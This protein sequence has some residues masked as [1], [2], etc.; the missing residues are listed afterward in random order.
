MMA[1]YRDF[2]SNRI[3]RSLLGP[4]SDIFAGQNEEEV[5]SD[6]PLQRY[7][8]GILF[9]EKSIASPD[10]DDGRLELSEKEDDDEDDFSGNEDDAISGL[11][12]Q[13][14][15]KEEDSYIAANQYFPTN[16]GL[17]VCLKPDANKVNAIVS[18]AIY[19]LSKPEDVKI[20]ISENNKILLFSY[21]PNDTKGRLQYEDGK[22]F[23]IKQPVGKTKGDRS[24]DYAI[25]KQLRRT[26]ELKNSIIVEKFEQ[27]LTPENRLWK[28]H[29][30]TETILIDLATEY[31]RQTVTVREEGNRKLELL[32]KVFVDESSGNKYIKLLLYNASEKHTQNRFTNSDK[33]LNTNCFYQV[34]ITLSHSAILPYKQPSFV[35][36]QFD[37]E[38][39]LINY[40]YRSIREYGIGHGCAI[41]SEQVGANIN[42]YT[43]FLPEVNLPMVSNQLKDNPFFENIPDEQKQV[44]S[45]LLILK[46]LSIWSGITKD[47]ILQDLKTFVDFYSK[48]IEKQKKDANIELDYKE[49]SDMLIEKQ[50]LAL[51][52]LQRS[53]EL[54]KGNE[55]AFEC[56]QYT[57]TAM[58]IQLITSTDEQFAKKQKEL[59][60]LSGGS[61]V[62]DSLDFFKEYKDKGDK[63]FAYRPFQLVFLLLNLNSIINPKDNLDRNLVDLLWFPTGGGKTEAYLAVTAFTIL[64]RRI[65]HPENYQGVSV[66][67][68]YTLRLLTAQQFERASRLICA[69]EFLRCKF[70]KEE[71]D[72]KKK[73]RVYKFGED[74]ITIGMW[75]GSGTTP[76]SFK[77]AVDV[78][79]EIEDEVNRLNKTNTDN[80]D[81]AGEKNNFQ[82]EACAW[83]G[84]KVISKHPKTNKY[85]LAFDNQGKAKC[86]N[87]TCHFSDLNGNGLPI[88]VVDD[89]L[90]Q[91]PPTLLFATVDKF[92]ML[93]HKAEGHKFFNSKDDNL[94]PPDLIIQDELHL[95]NGPLG[96]VVGLFERVV[97]SL[98]T[99]NDIKPKIIAS[100]ATTRNT[101]LQTRNLYNREVAVFPPS[102]IH[103][104]DSFFAFTLKESHRKYIGFMPTGKTG[105]DT[106]LEFLAHLLFARAELL[107]K[108]RQQ[109]G[110][111][112][113]NLWKSLD[114]YF[115]L[116]S[117]YNSLKDVGK[118]YNKVNAEV[119]DKLRLLLQR[120]SKNNYLYDFMNRG[121][122]SRTREL[123][124][125]IPSN[126]I[127]PV[128]NELEA[129][130]K[131]KKNPENGTFKIERG[132]DLVLASNMI[133]VGID[134][135]RLN[136][137]LI[138]GQPRNVSE[139][140]QASS[141]VA[142]RNEGIVFNLLDANRA[143]EKS[144]FENYQ[145]FHH[146][147]YK[148]VEP[149]SLTPNTE[150][151]FD[152]MLNAVLVC[153]VRHKQGLDA[154]Q[155]T[156]NTIEFE[157]I[158]NQTIKEQS[159]QIHLKNELKK[160]ADDWI[161]K[162]Q[163]AE[164]IGKTLQYKS[165]EQTLIS[166]SEPWNLMF[167][168]REIDK[169][170]LILIQK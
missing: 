60:K 36:N 102:G 157:K 44:F 112:D 111:D 22:L 128:L 31:P 96:S 164:S 109:F 10:E 161:G 138:N 32:S 141:R 155:F 16:C 13:T 110:S 42:V 15:T 129:E 105:M 7:Y 14:T 113:D 11:M 121:L 100:T 144:Y 92:A 150:I 170:G 119:Y 124:S 126:R 40:Q 20:D 89:Y 73:K 56:F 67:M 154:H 120:F 169:Q 149:L 134:V 99:K 3:S 49:Y 62:Y 68:R 54:L 165:K 27:L 139:Y 116:V 86:L 118:T 78:H 38:A 61:E 26:E 160:L 95:L 55:E 146:A 131:V 64:W 123:T 156:G 142:R 24:G 98:C 8:T 71:D 33:K 34:R 137:M 70:I 159:L 58:Y 4:G 19:K 72:G 1:Q 104:S 163:T 162:V 108:L 21:L 132:I 84:C 35:I 88:F 51:N 50:S 106:Q 148:F 114:P 94:L 45:Q 75:V 43:T 9:P 133:S 158:I 101:E 57:N 37:P 140:I 130:L 12:K 117:Y 153:Y 151:T 93:P 76:N 97:E 87:D 69:L 25:P 90:Y 23:F 91:N 135:G 82:I 145:S 166:K 39:N 74:S 47:V 5:I 48:W 28:R 2:F 18:G 59:N 83:C 103:Y 53:I 125:R 77:D 115:T 167:S 66:M 147:Y 136:L 6:Y 127:K 17:T 46:N 65:K 122:I 107:Q 29:P 52:R 143:R 80:T 63:P 41:Q 168:M 30:F 152:K 81:S 79:K 85:L